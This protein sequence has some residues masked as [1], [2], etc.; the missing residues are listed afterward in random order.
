M[1]CI[2]PLRLVFDHGDQAIIVPLDIK[3]RTITNR[4]GVTKAFSRVREVLP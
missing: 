1:Q 2:D 3:D 4:I